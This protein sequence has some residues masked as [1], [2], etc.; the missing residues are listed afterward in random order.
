MKTT[1]GKLFELQEALN[2]VSNLRG[3]KFVYAAAKNKRKIDTEC[4]DISK[5]IEPTEEYKPI[6]EKENELIMKHCLKDPEGNPIPNN[7]GN[8]FVPPKNKNAFEADRN[9]L[10]AEYKEIFDKREKQVE[11]YKELL[12]DEIEI[13]LHMVKE[14]DLP[15]DITA[16]QLTGIMDMVE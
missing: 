4:E 14:E 5:V 9:K 2:N 7:Q 10:K 15:E 3:A 1:K 12:K 6:L 8:F 11:D 16:G 13:E